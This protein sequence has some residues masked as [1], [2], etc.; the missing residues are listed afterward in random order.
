LKLIDFINEH[1][2]DI[3]V[4]EVAVN[5]FE[6]YNRFLKLVYDKPIYFT[7]EDKTVEIGWFNG[8]RVIDEYNYIEETYQK[9]DFYNI[10]NNIILYYSD[11]VEYCNY[12]RTYNIFYV[13]LDSYIKI[14]NWLKEFENFNNNEVSGFEIR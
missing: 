5:A 14:D 4:E 6:M 9:S 11:S 1:N 8:L 13:S 12:K 10:F 2:I 3:E 7:I